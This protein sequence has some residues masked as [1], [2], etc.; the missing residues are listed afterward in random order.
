MTKRTPRREPIRHVVF[1]SSK[2]PG[3]VER[4][5]DGLSMLAKIPTVSHFEVGKNRKQDSFS[6]E[7]DVIVYAEFEDECA[8]H[9]YR[10]HPIYQE[11]IEIVRPLRELRIA[12]DFQVPHPG[13]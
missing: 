5:A 2:D 13:K 8:M 10:S 3:D 7:V 9:A 12:A 1:F 4:I 11:C 6:N